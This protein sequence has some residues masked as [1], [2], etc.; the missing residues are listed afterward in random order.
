[1]TGWHVEFLPRAQREFNKLP[2]RPQ[3]RILVALERV[4][5]TGQGDIKALQGDRAGRARLR[6]GDYR[7]IFERQGDRLVILVVQVGN[8][9]DL[10]KG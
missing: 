9:R 3:E 10:Y 5:E 1:M 2:A 8:R 6:V 7:V 4:A